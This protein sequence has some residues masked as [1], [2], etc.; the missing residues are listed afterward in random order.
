MWVQVRPPSHQLLLLQNTHMDCSQVAQ[1]PHCVLTSKSFNCIGSAWKYRTGLHS[2][3]LSSNPFPGTSNT[4]TLLGAASSLKGW[5]SQL[6]LKANRRSIMIWLCCRLLLY[7]VKVMSA[8][9]SVCALMACPC[10]LSIH[11]VCINSMVH[12]AWVISVTLNDHMEYFVSAP[13]L[14]LSLCFT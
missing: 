13:R 9:W 8:G 3:S 11:M 14:S 12:Y 4:S 7:A 5:R 2:L 1:Q 10:W 6:G